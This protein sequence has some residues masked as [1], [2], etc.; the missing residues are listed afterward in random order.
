MQMPRWMA[1]NRLVGRH[2]GFR[3]RARAFTLIELLVVIAI[4]ALLV[5]ILLPSMC[6]AR[7]S[8][9]KAICLSNMRGLGTA[10]NTY[11]T[12][13]KERIA[14]FTWRRGEVYAD[15]FPATTMDNEAAIN[16]AVDILRRRAEM[17][18]FPMITN[19]IPHIKYSHLV[20]MDYLQARLPE[21]MLAC[22]SDRNLASWQS[23]ALGVVDNPGS[24]TPTPTGAN[25]GQLVRLPFSSSYDLVPFAIAP[26]RGTATSPTVSYAVTAGPAGPAHATY[27]VP[28]D[29][30]LGQRRLSEV[31]QPAAKVAMYDPFTRHN[32]C[33]TP[34][35]W[36][37]Y[38][39]ST[40]PVLFWDTSVRDL[41][42][43][44]SNK[45]VDPNNHATE[46]IVR[47][48]PDLAVEPAT[49]NGAPFALEQ[50]WYRWTKHGLNG[51]DTGGSN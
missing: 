5:A 15:G 17:P 48:Q 14:T 39:D 11:G 12:D 3:M 27:R 1:C 20:L 21:K 45:G 26:D 30:N 9:K 42:S 36:F 22:P 38:K 49:K 8:A 46:A 40:G 28:G 2:E 51:I 19:W 29:V 10:F 37:G 31:A 44:K 18:S 7:E 24:L 25:T 35:Q 41:T 16:Q 23:Q 50:T 43:G 34:S 32:N 13:F 4:I 47:Y 6:Q 33:R